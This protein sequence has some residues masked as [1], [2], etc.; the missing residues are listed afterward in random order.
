M[1]Q[2]PAR[3]HADQLR[4]QARELQRAAAAGDTGALARIRAVSDKVTL[5]TAQLA[6]AREYGFPSW[7]RLVQDVERGRRDLERRPGDPDFLTADAREL[8]D[9]QYAD[10][11][12]LRPVLD[13]VLAVLPELGPA[14]AAA[15]RTVVSLVTPCRTFAAVRATT[16]SRVD[17]GL[18][19]DHTEPGGRLQVARNIASGTINL[20][21]PLN[22]P[23]DIDE[24]VAGWMRRAYEENSAPPAPRRPARRRAPELGPLAVLIEGSGLPGRE[25]CPENGVPHHNVHVALHGHGE[26]RPALAMPG[27]GGWLAVEPVP[28]DA[29][30]VRWEAPVTVRRDDDGLD[31]S[32]PFVRGARDDRHLALAWGDVPG[33]GTLRLFRGAKLR[34]VDVDPA[35][36]EAAMAPGHRLVARVRLTYDNGDP[37]CARLHPPYLEWSAG[38]CE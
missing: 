33:D 12:H 18:R 2:L 38:R 28:A 25:C 34:L 32:G 6:L 22:G 24:E 10:R 11:P 23:G 31:F 36:I 26:D 35:L 9:G 30:S 13:A 1:A 4:R 19:L 17:L 37:V 16:K 5:S 15:R 27:R 8:I 3:P 14:T 29:A 21:I 7:R 20:R